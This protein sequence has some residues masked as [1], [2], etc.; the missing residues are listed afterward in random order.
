MNKRQFIAP[1]IMLGVS[2]GNGG[3]PGGHS[4]Q[5]GTHVPDDFMTY[6]KWQDSE[7]AGFDWY[8]GDQATGTEADYVYF[9]IYEA[10]YTKQQIL[11]YNPGLNWENL[12]D[13]WLS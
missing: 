7:Y 10:C 12:Y 2:G 4:D 9:C 13:S 6:S 5:T 8:D 1:Y 3:E 11:E